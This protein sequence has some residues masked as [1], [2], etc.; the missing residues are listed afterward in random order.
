M[1]QEK[2]AYITIVEGPPPDFKNVSNEWSI[3][4]LEGTQNQLISLCEMR[5]FNGPKLVER[6]EQAWRAGRAARLDF[7]TGEGF[8]KELDILAVRWEAVEE[9]HKLYLWV[10]MDQTEKV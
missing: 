6:C 2:P 8:R 5:T 1:E 9:G 4:V 7:P 3:G 10:K